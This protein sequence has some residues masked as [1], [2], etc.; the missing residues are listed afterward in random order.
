MNKLRLVARQ[1]D[2]RLRAEWPQ[3]AREEKS[4]QDGFAWRGLSA[5][6]SG[7]V[8]PFCIALYCAWNLTLA[9]VAGVFRGEPSWLH[10]A[11]VVAVALAEYAFQL[12]LVLVAQFLYL[13][14][15]WLCALARYVHRL[16]QQ[17]FPGAPDESAVVSGELSQAYLECVEAQWERLQSLLERYRGRATISLENDLAHDE[18]LYGENETRLV[19]RGYVRSSCEQGYPVRLVVQSHARKINV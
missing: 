12:V 1:L 19:K 5:L 6:S 14:Y 4:R 2:E 11:L 13:N 18:A 17:E 15:G 8:A 9:H 3:L 7:A 16:F 10:W